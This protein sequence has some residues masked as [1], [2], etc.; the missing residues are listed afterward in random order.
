MVALNKVKKF[1]SLITTILYGQ[2]FLLTSK[3]MAAYGLGAPTPFYFLPNAIIREYLALFVMH[4]WFHTVMFGLMFALSVAL[5][6][7]TL[8]TQGH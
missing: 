2:E 5:G 3:K 7:V 1:L 6:I 4:K 8:I